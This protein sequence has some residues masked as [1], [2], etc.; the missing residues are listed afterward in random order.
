[1]L[2]E[3]EGTA[4]WDWMVSQ[5][6]WPLQEKCGDVG[7]EMAGTICRVAQEGTLQIA[8]EGSWDSLRITKPDMSV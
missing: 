8:P 5:F 3:S 4:L 2:T 6:T 1:M 7:L